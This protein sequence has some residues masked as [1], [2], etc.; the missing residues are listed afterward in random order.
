MTSGGV[1]YAAVFERLFQELVDASHGPLVLTLLALGLALFG[2]YR[3]CDARY[4]KASEIT[5]S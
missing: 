3:L 4:R 1:Y 2:A 5:H